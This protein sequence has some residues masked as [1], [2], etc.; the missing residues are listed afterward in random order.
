VEVCL[1]GMY[2]QEFG[3]ECSLPNQRRVYLSY[4][5]SVKYFRPDVRT[6]RGEALRTFVYHEILVKDLHQ[7]VNNQQARHKDCV[8]VLLCLHQ[9]LVVL[10]GIFPRCYGL[11]VQY[12]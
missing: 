10:C 4:L 7:E 3:V 9:S 12:G 1:F 2:V 6:V 5:D 11:C 8:C